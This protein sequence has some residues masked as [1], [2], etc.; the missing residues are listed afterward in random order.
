[1]ME[2]TIQQYVEQQYIE[3]AE[4]DQPLV[5][6]TL[7]SEQGRTIELKIAFIFLNNAFGRK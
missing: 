2:E 6:H 7:P 3:P 5:D 4:I 1:M